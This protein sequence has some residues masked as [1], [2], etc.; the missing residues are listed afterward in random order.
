MAEK[1]GRRE[2]S[3]RN[4]L[5]RHLYQTED[6]PT[7]KKRMLKGDNVK[8][9]SEREGGGVEMVH[10]WQSEGSFNHVLSKAPQRFC[11]T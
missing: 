6:Q 9:R 7:K 2:R 8:N 4:D 3:P 11:Y 5:W 10:M 1:L